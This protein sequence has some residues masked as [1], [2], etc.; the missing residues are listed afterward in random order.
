MKQKLPK[1]A[2]IGAGRWGKNLIREFNEVADIECVIHKDGSE[3][4]KWLNENYPEIKELSSLSNVIKR[5][6][7]DAVVIATPIETHYDIT[8]E[9]LLSEKHVFVEKPITETVDQ[10]SELLEIANHKNLILSVGF[11]FL[12][13]QVFKKVQKI[14]DVEGIKELHFLWKKYGSFHSNIFDNLFTHE[15]ALSIKLIGTPIN[16]ELLSA[17]GLIPEIDIIDVVAT[18]KNDITCTYKID[19]TSKER[20]KVVEIITTQGNI[21]TWRDD[22]LYKNNQHIFTQNKTALEIECNAFID[23][24]QSKKEPFANA[25]LGL[26]AV[27]AVEMVRP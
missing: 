18:F 7:I 1:I 19:R 26:E 24:I 15:I 25:V 8:K 27:K 13:H 16:I 23:D 17:Q 14:Q 5:T 9:I 3:T 20:E 12:H 11:I 21:Y 4:T 22:S 6:D 2:I 10:A